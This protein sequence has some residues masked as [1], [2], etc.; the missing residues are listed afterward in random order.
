MN[1]LTE[2]ER[3]NIRAE[4]KHLRDEEKQCLKDLVGKTIKCVKHGDLDDAGLDDGG[5]YL[6]LTFEDD[7]IFYLEATSPCDNVNFTMH[8]GV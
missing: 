7:T 8:E 1:G 6:K 4:A 3:A 2:I 5:E